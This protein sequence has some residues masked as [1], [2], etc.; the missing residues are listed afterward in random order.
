MTLAILFSLKTME[1]LENGLEPQSG[2]TPL[3]LPT[4]EAWDKVMFYICLSVHRGGGLCA[5]S[6]VPWG[7]GSLSG[8]GSV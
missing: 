2:A 4:N 1:S 7:G 8:G 6:H 5:W 3:L